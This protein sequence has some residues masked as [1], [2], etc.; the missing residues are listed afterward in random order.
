[1]KTIQLT[2]GQVALVDDADYE[3]LS[4]HKWYA[5]WAPTIGSYYA[6]RHVRGPDGKQ[7]PVFMHREILG[8]Y[9][10]DK[11]QSDHKNHETLDNQRS[12]LNIVTRAQNQWNRRGT[13]GYSRDKKTGK[14]IAHIRHHGKAMRLGM[15]NTSAMARRAYVKAKAKYHKIK[16]VDCLPTVD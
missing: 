8:L 1:M 9:W 15:W 12:N 16:L 2:R 10:G 13:K 3:W 7:H 6:V 14:Y 11:R 5:R 4:L